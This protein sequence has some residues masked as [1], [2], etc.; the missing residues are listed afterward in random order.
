M[1]PETAVISLNRSE[2][3]RLRIHAQ[4]LGA[5]R[6]SDVASAVRRAGAIQAQDR[7]GYLLGV[8]TRTKGLTAADVQQ[9]RNVDRT[10]VRSWFMRGTLHLVPA[11]DFRWMLALVGEAMDARA[12]KH[13][14]D[15]GILPEDHARVL[16][17]FRAG[18][19]GRGFLKRTEIADFLNSAGLPAQ[20]QAARHLLRSASLLGVV[21]FG[22]DQDGEESHVPIDD[23]LPQ[24][25][26]P[27]PDP[28]A[29]LARRY[30][31][32]HG[33][34]NASDFRWWTGLPAAE[35]R[36]GVEAIA[37]E[38]TEVSVDG[39]SMWVTANAATRIEEVR[40]A[41]THK[42]RVLGPFDPYLLGYAKR[43]LG[44]PDPLLK[45]IN[46]GGG[47]IRSCIVID[48]R[49]V[50]I[51]DRKRRVSGLTVTVTA[52]EKLSDEAQTQLEAEFADIARFLETEINWTL[53]L[54]PEATKSG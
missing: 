18:L 17:V 29:E 22:P 13:R 15:L 39:T 10:V 8:G 42:L 2:A 36:R 5:D 34:A 30:F 20:G 43:D 3:R 48:G 14:A 27:P 54:D 21:C 26:I 9:A 16:E 4:G 32:A 12:S 6:A 49:L 40:S 46:A 37:D 31:A 24:D 28:M 38:L 41:S 7:L 47:M 35:T 25:T 33:P 44:V 1:P 53:M 50:G 23:W 19:P 51:W 52:F 45:R 11:E